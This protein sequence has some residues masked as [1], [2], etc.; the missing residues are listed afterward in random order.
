MAKS[1]NSSLS[2]DIFIM[3]L[4]RTENTDELHGIFGRALIVA[5]RFDSMCEAAANMI[6]IKTTLAAKTVCSDIEYKDFVSKLIERHTTLNGNIKSLGLPGDASEILHSAREARNFIAHE[7][8]R[9]KVGCLD[10][11]VDENILICE[12]SKLIEEIVYGDIII[13]TLISMQNN[14]PLPIN[15][16]LE[17]Y[18]EKIIK[19]VI[20]R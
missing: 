2:P 14:D 15:Y 8:T 13:S 17:A 10:T 12:V 20:E 1:K 3:D 7:L 5:T 19:W 18:K 16:S 11:T 6:K 9:G 4:E